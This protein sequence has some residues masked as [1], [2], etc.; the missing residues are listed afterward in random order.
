[1][2]F[3]S[4][5]SASFTR[6]GTHI[7]LVKNLFNVVN[8]PLHSHR[9][10]LN[11]LTTAWLYYR[12]YVIRKGS[13]GDKTVLEG[14]TMQQSHSCGFR[15]KQIKNRLNNPTVL[16]TCCILFCY[17]FPTGDFLIKWTKN[18][19]HFYE[20]ILSEAFKQMGY[21]FI[22]QICHKLTRDS[23]NRWRTIWI[24]YKFRLL[25]L[26]RIFVYPIKC[27]SNIQPLLL[28][29]NKTLPICKIIQSFIFTQI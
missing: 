16:S 22:I 24:E 14:K 13:N 26:V 11:P 28:S 19:S 6:G 21:W 9:Y 27:Q 29:Y 8:A 23:R 5:T 17:S 4:A 10:I 7:C 18:S 2:I 3:R 12:L 25:T 1:M 15:W 20:I